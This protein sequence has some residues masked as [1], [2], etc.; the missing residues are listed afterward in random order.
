MLGDADGAVKGSRAPSASSSRCSGRSGQS[1]TTAAERRQSPSPGLSHRA[2]RGRP[3][4]AAHARARF[5]R[6]AAGVDSEPGTYRRPPGGPAAGTASFARHGRRGTAASSRLAVR[7]GH[8]WVAETGRV[9]RFRYD[10]VT[11]RA[12]EPVVIIPDLPPGAHH[13]TRSIAFVRTVGST[14]RSARRAIF[15]RSGSPPR[16]DRQLRS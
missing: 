10:V 13:W 6:D 9:L 1:A 3:R 15:A 16:R 7:D 8:L 12:T 11:H 5:D 4:C 14:S 2:G